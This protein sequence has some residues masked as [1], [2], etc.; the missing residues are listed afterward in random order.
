MGI[1]SATLGPMSRKDLKL[2][3]ETGK[4]KLTV[5]QEETIQQLM[6]GEVLELE[7]DTEPTMDLPILARRS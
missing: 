5:E 7:E 3:K 6:R 1:I 4:F 2:L